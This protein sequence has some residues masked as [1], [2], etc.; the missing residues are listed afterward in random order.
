MRREGANAKYSSRYVTGLQGCSHA[1]AGFVVRNWR[2]FAP[3]PLRACDNSVTRFHGRDRHRWWKAR[4]IQ[5]L[6][7]SRPKGPGGTELDGRSDS[8]ATA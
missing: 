2:K 7:G 1:A 6:G 3:V 5:R 8:S 4:E